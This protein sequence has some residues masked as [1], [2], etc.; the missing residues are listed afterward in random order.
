MMCFLTFSAVFP[1]TWSSSL[2]SGS[3]RKYAASPE[4]DAV[5]DVH[6]KLPNDEIILA[7]MRP[8]TE[9]RPVLNLRLIGLSICTDD[10]HTRCRKIQKI[11]S[12]RV[13][14]CFAIDVD[15]SYHDHVC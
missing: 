13:R 6:S 9:R 5:A 7:K 15:G 2:R 14:P 3:E 10:S 1:S 12:L 8:L 11:A 4:T